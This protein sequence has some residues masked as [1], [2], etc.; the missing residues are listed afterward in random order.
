MRLGFFL[1]KSHFSLP[2]AVDMFEKAA[3]GRAFLG[4]IKEKTLRKVSC[5]PVWINE[6]SE[7]R[8]VTRGEPEFKR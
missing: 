8:F 1:R 7:P 3:N 5:I 6:R 4:V 2:R